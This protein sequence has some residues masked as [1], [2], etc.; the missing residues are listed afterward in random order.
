MKIATRL[1]VRFLI[2]IALANFSAAQFGMGMRPPSIAGVF[3]PVVGSGA[4]YDV[5]TKNGTKMTMDVGGG[6]GIRRLLA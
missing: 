5:V 2:T 1:F 3:N 6:Q 4:T